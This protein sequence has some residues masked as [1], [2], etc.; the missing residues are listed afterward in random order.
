[1][2]SG[3]VFEKYDALICDPDIATRIRLKTATTAVPRFGRI[4]HCGSLPEASE[5]L[6]GQLSFNVVFVSNRIPQE[7]ITSFI[8]KGRE[9]PQGQDAAY[10]VVLAGTAQDSS[11]VAQNV[12][13]GADGFLFE[14]YSVDSL[15]EITAL[16]AKVKRDRSRA[17]EAAALGLVVND[18]ISQIDIVA[19]LKKSGM[20]LGPNM[21]KL[22]EM[23]ALF[24]N[25]TKDAFAN[26]AMIAVE[27]FQAAPVPSSGRKK[28][29][30]V[31]DRVKKRLEEKNRIELARKAGLP[32]PPPEA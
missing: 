6:T 3:H 26:Y 16:A 19:Q 23:C 4:G 30:G 32:E 13:V 28:Y 12:M 10:I 18:V 9:T 20:D 27:K 5:A 11:T 17:R 21:K 25:L 14:P 31:S 2:N 29:G 22:R 15:V 1:M 8:L 7:E 24:R